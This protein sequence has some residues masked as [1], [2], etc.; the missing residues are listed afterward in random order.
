MV[1]ND[2]ADGDSDGDGDGADDGADDD[3]DADDDDEDGDDSTD[4]DKPDAATRRI[5]QLS[6]ENKKYRQ[7]AVARGKRVAELEAELAKLKP[8]GGSKDSEGAD[9]KPAPEVEE[10]KNTNSQLARTNEDLLIRLEFMG[11]SK[12]EWKNPKAALRLLDLSEVEITEDGE[13]EGLDEAIDALAESDSYLLKGKDDD[14]AE[15]RKRKTGQ[16][17][18]QRKTGNPNREKLISKYPALRR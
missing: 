3:D 11:N 16:Q 2:D 17:T 15:R 6:A 12:Y 13:V 7:R 18:G 8:T 9:D 10:L 5:Q 1:V 4:G 14:D